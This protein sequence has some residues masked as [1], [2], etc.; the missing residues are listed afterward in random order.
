M[1]QKVLE[2]LVDICGDDEVTEDKDINLFESGLLDSLGMIEL[3][4]ELEKVLNIK[5]QP[6]EINREDIETPNKI[7]ELISKR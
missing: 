2:I 7:I 3:L 4:I 6:T 5:I 1:E